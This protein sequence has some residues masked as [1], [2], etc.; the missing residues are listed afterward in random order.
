MTRTCEHCRWAD[1]AM[2]PEGPVLECHRYP[3]PGDIPPPLEELP[4]EADADLIELHAE[5]V[6]V[7][8]EI[9]LARFPSVAA[10][11]WCGDFQR[12]PR[13]RRN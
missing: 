12:R 7:A 11:D 3:P 1:I 9:D 8:V 4:E 10:N 5:A 2:R 13:W 6:E